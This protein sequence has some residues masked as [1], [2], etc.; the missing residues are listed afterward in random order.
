MAIYV[1]QPGDTLWDIARRFGV[2]VEE[3]MRANNLTNTEII[4]GQELQIIAVVEPA[5][6]AP[7]TVH[8][9]RPGETLFSIARRYGISVVDLIEANPGLIYPGLELRIPT[10]PPAEAPPEE[11]RETEC[12]RLT[13][14]TDRTTYRPGQPVTM[15]FTK[16]NICPRSQTLTYP[17]GQRY[18]FEVRQDNR[19]IW[20]WSEGRT[21]TQA[22]RRLRVRPRE[23]M[24]YTESWPQVDTNG[25]QVEPGRYRIVAWNTA[26]ELRDEVVTVYVEIR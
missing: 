13:L 10:A 14:S 15:K 7:R 23:T 3:I 11:T 17:T 25:R 22:V 20:R 5:P 21:F 4:P 26:R 1:V 6:S 9:V 2:T 18:E 19:L 12:F 8:V 24:V 16:T